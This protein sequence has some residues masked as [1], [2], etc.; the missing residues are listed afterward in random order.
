MAF[1]IPDGYLLAFSLKFKKLTR[2]MLEMITCEQNVNVFIF[3]ER[4][5]M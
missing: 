3:S 2:K 1:D 5:Q 4:V